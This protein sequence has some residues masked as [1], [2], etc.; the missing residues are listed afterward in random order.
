[1]SKQ[2]SSENKIAGK[3]KNL[4]AFFPLIDIMYIFI[5]FSLLIVCKV[6]TQEKHH[7]YMRHEMMS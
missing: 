4:F 3:N 5:P 2:Y 7:M 6:C 1:M